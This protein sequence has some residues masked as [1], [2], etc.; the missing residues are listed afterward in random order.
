MP[1]PENVRFIKPYPEI[2]EY[3]AQGFEEPHIMIGDSLY[4]DIQGAKQAGYE[5]I[6]LLRKAPKKYKE[7]TIPERTKKVNQNEK[8]LL[9]Y[10]IQSAPFLK[11]LPVEIDLN[12]FK[13][14]Y[15]ISNLN[16]LK[17]LF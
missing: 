7:C 1:D 12:D 6:W 8:F 10:L 15:V 9:K 5:T 14:D 3:T 4:F 16:E 17:E 2:F 13:P 11:Y